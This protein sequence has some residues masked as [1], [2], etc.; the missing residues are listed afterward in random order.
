LLTGLPFPDATFDVVFT[1]QVLIHISDPVAAIREMR[2]ICKP[3]GLL[4][5]RE[6]DGGTFTWY[7]D[8]S[9]LLAM[10]ND[11]ILTV[12]SRGGGSVR[13]GVALYTRYREGGLDPARMIKS[14]SPTCYSTPAERKWFGEQHKERIESS[15]MRQKFLEVGVTEQQLSAMGQALLDWANDVDGVFAVLQ[16]EVVCST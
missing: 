7:P 9:G 16:Y 14:T 1:H 10:Y 4:A 11:A 3:G 5:S 12:I 13:I 6:S 2:R 15:D 8:P